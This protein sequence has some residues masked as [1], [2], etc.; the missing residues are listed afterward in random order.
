M[1]KFINLG[2]I[3]ILLL[4]IIPGCN[5][6][7]TLI[8]D[9]TIYNLGQSAAYTIGNGASAVSFNLHYF[10]TFTVTHNSNDSKMPA[11]TTVFEAYWIAETVV[12]YQL[13]TKVYNWATDTARGANQ[14]YF[15]HPGEMGYG[16]SLTDQHPVTGIN[17]RDVIIWCNALTE[18]YNAQNE[19]SVDCVYTYDSTI[20]RD[21]RDSNTL[22]C[23]HA[24][25]NPTAKGFRLPARGEWQMAACYDRENG[26]N[27]WN[28]VS[29]DNTSYCYPQDAGT[30]KVFGNYAWYSDNS[31]GST[32][33]VGTKLANSLGLYDMSGNVWQWCFD[34]ANDSVYF[35]AML[36]GSWLDDAYSLQI[37]TMR[38]EFTRHAYCNIGFRLVK[39][40]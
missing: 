19:T 24:V 6:N 13:W 3:I 8:Q 35:R 33:P 28:R 12:T 21:S 32:H 22:A 17:W 38:Y 4:L 16:N 5:E 18:Y 25:A 34:P 23:D 39:S 14:Y 30:S 7:V 36:G 29:G 9:G 11:K 1:K 26:F 15:Q 2:I 31:G 37:R 20:I 10:P 27:S 40:Q